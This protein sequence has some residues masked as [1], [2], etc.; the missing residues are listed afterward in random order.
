M[1]LSCL[2]TVSNFIAV[3]LVSWRV[4]HLTIYRA[5]PE[6]SSWWLFHPGLRRTSCSAAFHF[7]LLGLWAGNIEELWWAPSKW[8]EGKCTS[9]AGL[10]RVACKLLTSWLSSLCLHVF[11]TLLVSWVWGFCLSVF[12]LICA[13][14]SIRCLSTGADAHCLCEEKEERKADVFNLYVEQNYS[15]QASGWAVF[16]KFPWII[17]RLV[18]TGV[19]VLHQL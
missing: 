1:Q 2:F 14:A 5:V 8:W 16:C 13:K 15:W 12:A 9:L 18:S 7:I 11:P 3:P 17:H 6:T 4:L 10:Q 19:G